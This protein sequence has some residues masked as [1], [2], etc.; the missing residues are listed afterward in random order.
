MGSNQG[1]STIFRTEAIQG[2]KCLIISKTF[3]LK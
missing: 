2:E 3:Q 1:E